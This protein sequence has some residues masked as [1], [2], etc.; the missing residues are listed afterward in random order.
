MRK[1]WLWVVIVVGGLYFLLLLIGMVEFLLWMWCGEYL[2]DVYV[3]VLLDLVFC[4]I[5]GYLV[6]MVLLIIL[7][8]ILVVV[9]IVYWVW[10]CLL[11]LCLVI[12]FVI[13]LLL[14][15]LVIVVVF[16]YI[17]LYNISLWLLLI[18]LGGMIN[19]LLLCGYVMLVLF[20]MYCVIDIG[21]LIMDVCLLIEVV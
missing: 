19:L 20:Y 13:F 8:G 21:L 14:V 2:L 9:F 10:L 6:V 11:C 15:I 17:W 1:F 7:L 12:E 4:V 3:L 18:G 16:G 5:F